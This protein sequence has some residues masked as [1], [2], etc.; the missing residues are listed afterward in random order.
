[1]ST[2]N[3]PFRRRSPLF[4]TEVPLMSLQDQMNRLFDGFFSG[5]APFSGSSPAIFE[6]RSPESVGSFVPKV[7]ITEDEKEIRVTAELPGLD[8]K[9]IELSLTREALTLKG[10]KRTE[11]EEKKDGGRTLYVERSFGT[12]QRVIPLHAE[13]V[14]D[15]VDASF[16]KGVLTISLPKR[17]GTGNG[18]KKI[19]VR[20]T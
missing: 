15:K 6:D 4:R 9:D 18:T 2:E 3:L 5:F 16:R 11:V 19:S 13:V 10:Q 20:S 8:E 7:N 17:E 14:E 12:F 1:M